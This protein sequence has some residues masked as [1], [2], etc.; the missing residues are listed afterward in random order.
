M[1]GGGR[2]GYVST[3]FGRRRYLNDIASHNAVARGLA[4]R[5][6]ANPPIQGSAADTT[7]SAMIRVSRRFQ[8]FVEGYCRCTS[9]SWWSICFG[10]EQERVIAIV[11]QAMELAAALR[12][13]LA[14]DCGARATIGSKR[15][16]ST[17]PPDWAAGDSIWKVHAAGAVRN[18]VFGDMSFA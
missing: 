4:E 8:Y 18:V 15:M 10:S 7:A 14:A 11:T 9:T 16:L 6:A 1:T 5:N 3:I 2:D 17:P 13:R 12:V